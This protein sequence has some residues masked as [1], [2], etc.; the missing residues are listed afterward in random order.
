MVK[1]SSC[2]RSKKIWNKILA[3]KYTHKQW[4]RRDRNTRRRI[5]S[6]RKIHLIYNNDNNN[7][8]YFTLCCDYR[9]IECLISQEKLFI[10][11]WWSWKGVIR[12]RSWR[13]W[14]LSKR[15][16][17]MSLDSPSR[18]AYVRYT[19]ILYYHYCIILT[20]FCP[21]MY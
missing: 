19:F 2:V 16:V 9:S 17:S 10:E 18:F 1:H 7:Y 4:W 12:F 6:D 3:P 15:K 5:H 13:I 20:L 8:Y 14:L 21:N 11:P